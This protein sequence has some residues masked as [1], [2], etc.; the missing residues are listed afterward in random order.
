MQVH[1]VYPQI[2]FQ[3]YVGKT[4][5]DV[6]AFDPSKEL[7][8]S[9]RFHHLTCL[10]VDVVAVLG[11][12]E[13]FHARNS[14]EFHEMISRYI[15]SKDRTNNETPAWWP[16]I[17]KVSIR[18]ASKALSTGCVRCFPFGANIIVPHLEF[19]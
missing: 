3:D 2:P 19:P 5:D 14:T 16:L 17:L 13:I 11:S 9:P 8:T 1:A 12:T 6:M 18:C 10:Y 4:V 15:D 7:I